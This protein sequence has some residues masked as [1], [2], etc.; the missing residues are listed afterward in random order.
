VY[1]EIDRDDVDFP[2]FIIN[3]VFLSDTI[4][5][6]EVSRQRLLW[7]EA[8]WE[9]FFEKTAI[10]VSTGL[11][12]SPITIIQ[13]SAVP[14]ASTDKEVKF[15]WGQ[16]A[17]GIMERVEFK[18]ADIP[19]FTEARLFAGDDGMAN[20]LM[21]R[22]KY[23]VDI[24]TLGTTMFMPGSMFGLDPSPLDLGFEEDSG[25]SRAKSLGLGGRYCAH[26]IEHQVDLIEKKWT[27]KIIGKWE[28]FYDAESG[29]ESGTLSN[30]YIR[31]I[32]GILEIFN[33]I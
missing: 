9:G 7:T 11:P 23:N 14:E 31:C 20:N 2:I 22:E 26:S 15:L 21:L 3:S 8:D 4:T 6:A 29:R 12:V 33:G 5:T 18:R 24:E 30:N 17:R 10:D 28:S 32:R 13:Q 27:T 16:A 19:G 1:D 25:M